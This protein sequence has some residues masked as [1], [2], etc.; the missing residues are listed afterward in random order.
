MFVKDE[1]NI[2]SII[3]D[4]YHKCGTKKAC[5]HR[6]MD[7]YSKIFKTAHIDRL[8]CARLPQ[9]Q[10]DYCFKR[11]FTMLCQSRAIFSR[12]TDNSLVGTEF[13]LCVR[14]FFLLL[15]VRCSIVSLSYAE[16]PDYLLDCTAI[17]E[18]WEGLSRWRGLQ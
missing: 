12:L 11:H 4:D 17:V 2:Q 6:E 1:V 18:Y 13:G 10:N 7:Q 15:L 5:P 9:V 16:R 3:C 8:S 14:L